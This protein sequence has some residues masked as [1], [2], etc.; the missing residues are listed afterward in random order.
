[1]TDRAG[2]RGHGV[3]SDAWRNRQQDGAP[4][5]AAAVLSAISVAA[6]SR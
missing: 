6:S 5:G 2:V 1:M 3:V 4:T